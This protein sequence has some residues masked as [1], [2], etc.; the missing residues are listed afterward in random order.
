MYT[1]MDIDI[2]YDVDIDVDIDIDSRVDTVCG[3]AVGGW[4][5]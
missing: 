5:G 1:G 2:D 4:P 3:C